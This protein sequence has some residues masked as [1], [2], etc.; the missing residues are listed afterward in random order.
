MALAKPSE[1]LR[2]L[3]TLCCFS[4]QWFGFFFGKSICLLQ[5]NWLGSNF[6]MRFGKGYSPVLGPARPFYQRY[7]TAI[8]NCFCNIL[9]S[10]L[11][12]KR[13]GAFRIIITVVLIST[14]FGSNQVGMVKCQ[15]CSVENWP[16][17][18]DFKPQFSVVFKS[19]SRTHSRKLHFEF[20]IQNHRIIEFVSQTFS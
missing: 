17:F 10:Y 18:F 13:Y 16:I 11:S 14:N 4:H 2:M 6:S 9:L 7:F 20:L 15:F 3:P 8:K 19:Q 1:T 12:K 5:C